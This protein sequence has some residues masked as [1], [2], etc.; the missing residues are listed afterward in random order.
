MLIESTAVEKKMNYSIYMMQNF[1]EMKHIQ[2]KRHNKMEN[3]K[4]LFDGTV[5]KIQQKLIERCKIDTFKGKGH[6][7]NK[8]ALTFK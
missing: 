1:T 8:L 3:K 4:Y 2:M 6:D 7:L 5:L